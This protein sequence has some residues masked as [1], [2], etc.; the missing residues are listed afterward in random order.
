MKCYKKHKGVKRN[1]IAF[2]VGGAVVDR[3]DRFLRVGQDNRK[4]KRWGHRK[5]R[6]G[7]IDNRDRNP[8][9]IKIES[10]LKLWV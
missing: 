7:F 10:M 5:L 3:C 9:A 6:E 2:E 8:L 4:A 1:A